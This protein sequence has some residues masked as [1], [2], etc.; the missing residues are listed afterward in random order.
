MHS[1]APLRRSVSFAF[2]LL[3]CA[4]LF[5]DANAQQRRRPRRPTPPSTA[6]T[7]ADGPEEFGIVAPPSFYLGFTPGEDRKVADWI[8]ITDYFKRLDRASSR[9]EVRAVGES[10]Q[11]RPLIAAFISRPGIARTAPRRPRRSQPQLVG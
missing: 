1:S 9:V 7:I 4:L 6:R 10:T 3:L 11:G 8:Q 2:A 5:N